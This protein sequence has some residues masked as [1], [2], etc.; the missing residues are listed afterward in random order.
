MFP[1]EFEYHCPETL[2][3]ALDLLRDLGEE[4]RLLAGG[5]SLLAGM[6]LRLSQPSDLIDLSR[7]KELQG[8]AVADGVLS[9][10]AM[11]SHRELADSTIAKSALP[12]LTEAAG[13]V[14]D[15]QVRNR[16]TIGGSLVYNDPAADYPALILALDATMVCISEDGERR[17]PAEEWL[18]SLMTSA[19]QPDEILVRIEFPLP[20]PRSAA[21]YVKVSHPASRF[22]VIGVAVMVGLDAQ[23]C[24][25]AMRVAITGLAEIA[26]RSSLLEEALTG[27]M[28]GKDAIR[29]AALA[30]AAALPLQ[31]DLML[32][33]ESKQYLC[34]RTIMRAV[35]EARDR[36][37]SSD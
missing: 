14:A 15:P 12:C 2:D 25:S 34:A 17:I 20:L 30:A 23:N 26:E 9:V 11:T 21:T 32:D 10:G 29:E 1:A 6:K 16:G 31:G 3:E 4:A 19:I 13:N 24:C 5:Q 35:G 27:S 7:V 22:A 8:I 37:A 28:L 36:V 18:E 33:E